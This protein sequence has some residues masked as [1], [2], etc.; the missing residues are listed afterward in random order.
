MFA[1][2]YPK[3]WHQ[4]AVL[5]P[6]DVLAYARDDASGTPSVVDFDEAARQALADDLWRQVTEGPLSPL[7]AA[8]KRRQERGQDEQLSAA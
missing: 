8:V 3:G 4:I 2:G 7:A 1:L 5:T 6:D